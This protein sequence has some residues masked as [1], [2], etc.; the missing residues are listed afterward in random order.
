M[1]DQITLEELAP[2][3]PYNLPMYRLNKLG[4]WKEIHLGLGN[5]G[6]VIQNPERY[7]PRVRSLMKFYTTQMSIEMEQDYR[8]IRNCPINGFDRIEKNEFDNLIVVFQDH[9]S[10]YS[11]I[12]DAIPTL[13]FL[14]KHHFDVFGWIERGL[15]INKNTLIEK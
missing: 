5:I 7:Q 2:F 8:S 3:L 4:E 1:K 11:L 13:N 14:Y 12:Y 6:D 15:A 9:Q 10:T